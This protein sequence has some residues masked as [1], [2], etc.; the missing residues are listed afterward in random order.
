[1]INKVT[2][3]GIPLRRRKNRRL[4]VAGYWA[5]VLLFLGFIYYSPVLQILSRGSFLGNGWLGF[6]C[7]ML[8][9]ILFGHLTTCLGGV[10]GKG[11]I[12]EWDGPIDE[13]DIRL[14]NAAHFEAYQIFRIIIVPIAMLSVIAFATV[15][16]HYQRLAVPLL[17]LLWF[18][19]FNL[20]Q[21]LIL[22]FEPDMEESK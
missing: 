6:P 4:L 19:V 9:G 3:L 2:Y 8:T 5:V 17:P 7:I 10:S 20:P 16:S 22:W 15:W 14:R 18:L 13:R 21:S 12:S 11:L 1:M